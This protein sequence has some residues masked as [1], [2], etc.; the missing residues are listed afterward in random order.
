MLKYIFKL[1]V[2][3]LIP[4]ISLAQSPQNPP[5]DGAA[6]GEAF[7]A[8]FLD[9][10]KQMESR[11]PKNVLAE[12]NKG[13][14]TNVNV[15]P[16]D[17]L[18]R[19][20]LTAGMDALDRNSFKESQEQ[21]NLAIQA[22]KQMCHA[23]TNLSSTMVNACIQLSL[24]QAGIG[25]SHYSSGN[26]K[27]AYDA[28]RQSFDTFDR[29]EKVFVSFS[30]NAESLD[31]PFEAEI[32]EVLQKQ[33]AEQR[34]QIANFDT[35][36]L[37]ANIDERTDIPESVRA[38]S[39][40]VMKSSFGSIYGTMALNA[41][42]QLSD[43]HPIDD[44]PFLNNLDSLIEEFSLRICQA[45]ASIDKNNTNILNQGL[46]NVLAS[47]RRDYRI[48]QGIDEDHDFRI[49]EVVQPYSLSAIT[50]YANIHERLFVGRSE[51]SK[52]FIES[53]RRCGAGINPILNAGVH[54][55]NA[56]NGVNEDIF[57]K[58]QEVKALSNAGVHPGFAINKFG[59]SQV[60]YGRQRYLNGEFDLG[61]NLM[62]EGLT[63]QLDK[64]LSQGMTNFSFIDTLKDF[65]LMANT[66]C[67]S[68]TVRDQDCDELRPLVPTVIE[69][70]SSLQMM[71]HNAQNWTRGELRQAGMPAEAAQFASMINGPHALQRDILETRL[72]ELGIAEIYLHFGNKKLTQQYLRGNDRVTKQ[73]NP[74]G[75]SV[76]PANLLAYE[77]YLYAKLYSANKDYTQASHHFD[78]AIDF[79]DQWKPLWSILFQIPNLFE[80]TTYLHEQAA[81]FEIDHGD[82]WK[83]LGYLEQARGFSYAQD[84][85]ENTET[86]LEM[87]RLKEVV[88]E[89]FHSL[90]EVSTNNSPQLRKAILKRAKVSNDDS[91]QLLQLPQ[92]LSNIPKL[93]PKPTLEFLKL[94]DEYV[95][96]TQYKAMAKNITDDQLRRTKKKVSAEEFKRLVGQVSADTFI[97][98]Y[99]ET[100]EEIFSYQISQADLKINYQGPPKREMS[101]GELFKRFVKPQLKKDK[102][103][104]V[105]LANGS[106]QQI[107]YAAM[108]IEPELLLIDDYQ[109]SYIP[110][111][112]RLFDDRSVKRKFE[113]ALFIAPSYLKRAKLETEAEHRALG[114][115]AATERW[116]FNPSSSYQEQWQGY[117]ILHFSAHAQLDPLMSDSSYILLGDNE[118]L[119]NHQ[120]RNM[121]LVD[122]QLIVLNAC[123]SA[124]FSSTLLRNEFSSFQDGFLEAGA[125]AVIGT[126]ERVPDDVAVSF[127][128]FFYGALRDEV[129]VGEAF[130][131]AQRKLRG[132]FPESNAWALFTLSGGF[133]AI[134]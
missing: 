120:I 20:H 13:K 66:L 9:L 42:R 27:G 71:L 114:G 1:I 129:S 30:N 86:I 82:P 77:N 36:Q 113:R 7:K 29:A 126:L 38:M 19:E 64:P 21:F 47:A 83:A 54:K 28:F 50:E 134:H 117:S 130:H 95:V 102:S 49:T 35:S 90:V 89:K 105:I 127:S 60:R 84:L 34:A 6:L 16:Y 11:Y 33:I 31:N 107:K 65:A 53:L 58:F 25:Q 101:T 76:Y 63:E 52:P 26:V 110:S 41:P 57:T 55:L 99:W 17:E 97:L 116:Q 37:V 8:Q 61:R 93:K 100:A 98:G 15:E 88:L 92:L 123:D 81:K 40:E 119:F 87:E 128:D 43:R 78:R 108:E 94:F 56:Y 106:L 32:N 14:K 10:Q 91:D 79:Y 125:G 44:K 3:I 45:S 132:K 118:K 104:L 109:L 70:L 73:L 122:S 51:S 46:N 18:A 12:I 121:S 67:A 72:M 85:V 115:L 24:A 112:S 5:I 39:K 2:L 96:L 22:L 111:L 59:A 68:S 23:E 103:K 133:L 124:N 48:T 74:D 80:T 75:D 4:S 69:R 131:I 62:R